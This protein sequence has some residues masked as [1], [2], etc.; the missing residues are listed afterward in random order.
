MRHGAAHDERVAE[1]ISRTLREPPRQREEFLRLAC[2]DDEELR[3]EVSDAVSWEQRMGSFMLQPAPAARSCRRP[4][5]PGELV[6]ERFQIIREIGEGGMGIVYEAFDR[7][8]RQ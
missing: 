8:R 7:K 4:F 6:A 3:A 2:G 5:E 1:L